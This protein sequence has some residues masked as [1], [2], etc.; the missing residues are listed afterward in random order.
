MWEELYS[1]VLLDGSNQKLIWVKTLLSFANGNC[2]EVADLT[3]GLIADRDSRATKG[4][5]LQFTTIEWHTFIGAV[6][7]REFESCSSGEPP[8][9]RAEVI[10]SR[11]PTACHVAWVD[12]RRESKHRLYFSVARILRWLCL[13]ERLGHR[14]KFRRSRPPTPACKLIM[15]S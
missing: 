8:D 10:D 7:P 13:D 3:G 1:Q 4:P 9:E 15:R 11:Q 6:E 5:V 12:N 14:N 2:V